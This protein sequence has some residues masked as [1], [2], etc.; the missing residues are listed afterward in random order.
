MRDC[1]SA[2]TQISVSSTTIFRGGSS[3]F[4]F[5]ILEIKTAS[6]PSIYQGCGGKR[7]ARSQAHLPC[8]LHV[9]LFHSEKQAKMQASVSE[10]VLG[11]ASELL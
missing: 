3:I 2:G 4:R 10:S 7:L 9:S 5:E 11:M 1:S 8:L 6:V